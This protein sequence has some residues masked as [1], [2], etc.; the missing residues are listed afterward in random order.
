MKLLNGLQ[1]NWIWILKYIE[2]NVLEI[3][4]LIQKKYDIVYT[5]KG[6]L[7]WI[8]DIDKW[9]NEI[10]FLLKKG[11]IFYIMESHPILNIF[12]DEIVGDLKVINSYFHTKNPI[13]YNDDHPDY[14]NK[15]Y[16]P[17]NKTYEWHWTMSDIVNA[18]IRNGM[19]IVFIHE[20]E[21]IFY[22]AFDGMVQ[23]NE[24]WWIMEKYKGKVPFVF[25]LKAEKE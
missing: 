9:A 10:S 2:S 5:S 7:C 1:K 16:I 6:I 21:K 22:K 4:N 11:G 8:S 20:Y 25:T 23:D 13:E 18:L 12:D 19:K 15:D 3:H 14:S 24:G 17:V